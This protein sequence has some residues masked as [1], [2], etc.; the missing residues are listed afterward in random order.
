MTKLIND[1]KKLYISSFSFSIFFLYYDKYL[2]YVC[3]DKVSALGFLLRL[4]R[5]PDADLYILLM[6]S[7]DGL[8]T[9]T[10]FLLH[11]SINLVIIVLR[12]LRFF[13]P[14]LQL[15]RSV[16]DR[17]W[18]GQ[19][20]FTSSTRNHQ[21]MAVQRVILFGKVQTGT[22]KN[23][24][25]CLIYICTIQSDYTTLKAWKEYNHFSM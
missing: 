8:S 22:R 1:V 2:M 4:I 19:T 3:H 24:Q 21:Y 5:E 20:S 25:K 6:S 12:L 9:Y 14:F 11:L 16:L 17:Y 10:P 23:I 13:L 7:G 18:R 15:C